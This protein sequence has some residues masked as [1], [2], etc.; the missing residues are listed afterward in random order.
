MQQT[1]GRFRVSG[2]KTMHWNPTTDKHVCQA[3]EPCHI[4]SVSLLYI[5]VC[6]PSLP[7][8]SESFNSESVTKQVQQFQDW[9]SHN[10]EGEINSCPWFAFLF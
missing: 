7:T 2:M 3:L 1:V 10:G 8:Q 5:A 6:F 9:D 4:S